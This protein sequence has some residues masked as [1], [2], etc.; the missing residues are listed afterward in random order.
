MKHVLDT[1][2]DAS[3]GSFRA[4][5]RRRLL[6]NTAATVR[7]L[8]LL[9]TAPSL[10]VHAELVPLLRLLGPRLHYLSLL[11]VPCLAHASR[12]ECHLETSLGPEPSLD[13]LGS[14]S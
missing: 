12:G 14:F 2:C 5:A 13:L 6:E 3:V 11:A 10:N 7:T 1:S 9:D 8:S 4:M